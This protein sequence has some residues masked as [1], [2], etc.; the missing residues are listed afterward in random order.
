MIDTQVKPP[1]PSLGATIRAHRER[2]GLSIRQL[3]TNAGVNYAYLSRV[4]NGTYENP[5]ADVL[6]RLAGALDID[7]GKLLR[8]IGIKPTTVIP[9]P[10]MY[11][12]KAYG[13]TPEQASEAAARM[14][15][16]VRELRNHKNNDNRKSRGGTKA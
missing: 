11:F 16:I 12:R 6:Q 7:A 3:A 4:E 15:Q 9:S 14:E 8:F 1:A 5:S 13:M 10:R 2:A